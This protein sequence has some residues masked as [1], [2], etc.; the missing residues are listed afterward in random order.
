M[1]TDNL[2]SQRAVTIVYHASN[3]QCAVERDDQT[4][5]DLRSQRA[6]NI[7]YLV[8]NATCSIER[9][10]QTINNLSALNE[11]LPSRVMY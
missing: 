3:A 9:Y 8:L 10:D 7:V 6:A 2:R 4:I 11:L 1:T 5:N